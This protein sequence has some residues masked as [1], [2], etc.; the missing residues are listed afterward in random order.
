[1]SNA[2]HGNHQCLNSATCLIQSAAI[3]PQSKTNREGKSIKKNIAKQR[4]Y[5]PSSTHR[6]YWTNVLNSIYNWNKDP[7][8][9]NAENR[10][11]EYIKNMKSLQKSPKRKSVNFP[12]EKRKISYW[13]D[14]PHRA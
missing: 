6:Q 12:K 8:E 14:K 7:R 2:K 4:V 5:I 3:E 1:M 11:R 10:P 13:S 9:K